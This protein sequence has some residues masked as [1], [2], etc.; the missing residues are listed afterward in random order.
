MDCFLRDNVN[1]INLETLIKLN[2][3]T[4]DQRK[5]PCKAMQFSTIMSLFFPQPSVLRQCCGQ[6]WRTHP[7]TIHSKHLAKP[8]SRFE[9]K[10]LGCQVMLGELLCIWLRV[11]SHL[12]A[13][14]FE[15][16]VNKVCHVRSINLPD[17]VTTP[18]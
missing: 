10:A 15:A 17:S 1:D 8:K 9:V 12:R 5:R 13:W 11:A 16:L 4:A 6:F 14:P 3:A 2:L 18:P 7:H